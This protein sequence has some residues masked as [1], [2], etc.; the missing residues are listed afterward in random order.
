MNNL[1]VTGACGF[2]GSH[3]CQFYLERGYNV[4]GLDNLLTGCLNN[5]NEF[6]DDSNFTFIEHDIRYKINFN[7]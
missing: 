3:L 6:K 7:D 4:I 5:I 1:M 2:L